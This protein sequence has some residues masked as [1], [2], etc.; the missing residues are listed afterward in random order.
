MEGDAEGGMGGT[1]VMRGGTLGEIFDL[2]LLF[3]LLL[4]LVVLSNKFTSF[5]LF[6]S[7]FAALENVVLLFTSLILTI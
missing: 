5:V 4:S 1:V 6:E 7:P 2:G 3:H